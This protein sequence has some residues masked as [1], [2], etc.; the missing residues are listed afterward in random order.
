M[1]LTA[2]FPHNKNVSAL[3]VIVVALIV[4]AVTVIALIAGYVWYV[5][6]YGIAQW[7]SLR[8][9]DRITQHPISN[10]PAS[11]YSED[12][13]LLMGPV[14]FPVVLEQRKPLGGCLP[15]FRVWGTMKEVTEIDGYRDYRGFHIFATASDCL[16]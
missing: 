4:V 3:I 2:S 8:G 16:G 10:F 9:T 13:D 14:T 15:E 6:Y 12:E 11:R 7:F 5:F 1:A